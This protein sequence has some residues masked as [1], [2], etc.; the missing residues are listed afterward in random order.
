M[1]VPK[2]TSVEFPA[3]PTGPHWDGMWVV[4]G[5][6]A[7]DQTEAGL[8]HIMPTTN[9]PRDSTVQTFWE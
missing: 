8:G 4:P 2:M 3:G 5:A 6:L 7:M 1:K 9:F